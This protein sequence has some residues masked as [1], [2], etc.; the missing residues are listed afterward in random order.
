M[1]MAVRLHKAKSYVIDADEQ[2]LKSREDWP[3]TRPHKPILMKK[4]KFY[5]WEAFKGCGFIKFWGWSLNSHM[6]PFQKK[7]ITKEQENY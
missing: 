3:P 1:D 4:P 2:I 5:W 6:I 7:N